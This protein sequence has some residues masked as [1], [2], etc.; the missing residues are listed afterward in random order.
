[1]TTDKKKLPKFVPDVCGECTQ[2]KTYDLGLDRGTAFIVLAVYNAVQRKDE[3]RVHIDKEMVAL[4]SDFD[5]L[6]HMI[7]EGFMTSSMQHNVPRARYHGLIAFVDKGTGEYL[8]TP[9]GARFLRGEAVPRIAIV[10]KKTHKKLAYWNED[11]DQVTFRDLMKKTEPFWNLND[12]AL[13]AISGGGWAGP[14]PQG[15]LAV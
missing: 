11:E 4:K 14:T 10:D 8:L 1:M 12:Q 13:A 9:K 7:S 3:N 15:A 6:E 5:S 2:T